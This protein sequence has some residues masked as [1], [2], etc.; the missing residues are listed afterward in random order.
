M[1]IEEILEQP[2]KS[3]SAE[4]LEAGLKDFHKSVKAFE[5]ATERLKESTELKQKMLEMMREERQFKQQRE[6]LY[7]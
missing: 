1:T 7:L 5:E 3:I 6:L 2:R 4:E